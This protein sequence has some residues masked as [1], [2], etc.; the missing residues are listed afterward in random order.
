[1]WSDSQFSGSLKKE[2]CIQQLPVDPARSPHRFIAEIGWCVETIV[3]E[4]GA[5]PIGFASK[6]KMQLL[7]VRVQ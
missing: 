2:S 4:A 6:V 1:L 5:T 3:G 7:A